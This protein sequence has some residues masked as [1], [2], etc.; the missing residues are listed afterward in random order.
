MLRLFLF[1]RTSYLYYLSQI[2][3]IFSAAKILR[4]SFHDERSEIFFKSDKKYLMKDLEIG[5]V[6][7][8]LW[9]GLQAHNRV[10]ATESI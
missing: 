1:L 8:F 9:T 3:R 6:S 7:G 10:H 2:E 4:S 5:N